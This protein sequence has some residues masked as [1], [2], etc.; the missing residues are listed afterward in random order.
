MRERQG[1]KNCRIYFIGK[2]FAFICLYSEHFF[3]SF[4]TLDDDDDDEQS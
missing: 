2:N 4:E 3:L 1:V